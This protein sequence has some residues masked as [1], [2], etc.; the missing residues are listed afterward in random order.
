MIQEV[1]LGNCIQRTDEANIARTAALDAGLG[2]EVTGLTVQRQCSSGMQ[3]IATGLAQ[4][5]LGDNEIVLAGGV[6]SMSNAPY[7]LKHSRWG[8]RLM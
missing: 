3:A 6:E 1:I 2:T 8:K 4:I 7:V 5:A